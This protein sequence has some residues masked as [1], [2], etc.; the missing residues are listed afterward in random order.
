MNWT[1]GLE[2]PTS[3]WLYCESSFALGWWGRDMQ[4]EEGKRSY[5]AKEPHPKALG[6]CLIGTSHG[7]LAQ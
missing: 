6:F 2:I 7:C 5:L 3:R 1:I 4:G